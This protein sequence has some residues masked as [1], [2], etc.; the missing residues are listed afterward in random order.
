MLFWFWDPNGP[1]KGL[2]GIR[3][4]SATQAPAVLAAAAPP[5][6]SRRRGLT[7]TAVVRWDYNPTSR[8][9][10]LVMTNKKLLKMAHL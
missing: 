10:P 2:T 5:T 1:S 3:A 7:E 6:E 9:Y 8:D 4:A